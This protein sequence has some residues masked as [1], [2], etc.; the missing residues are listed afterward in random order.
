MPCE[1]LGNYFIINSSIINNQD[2]NPEVV[3]TEVSIIFLKK[4]M[5]FKKWHY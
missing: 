4:K 3:F 2:H 5:F 1:F